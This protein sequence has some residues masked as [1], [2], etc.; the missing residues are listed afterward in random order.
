M[1]HLPRDRSYFFRLAF[2]SATACSATVLLYS[3]ASEAEQ[4][5]SRISNHSG[6]S[7]MRNLFKGFHGFVYIFGSSIVIVTSKTSWFTRCQVSVT[8]NSSLWGRPTLSIHVRSSNPTVS[9]TNV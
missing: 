4:I 7:L 1:H 3:C 8:F 2:L 9:V 5:I 6:C